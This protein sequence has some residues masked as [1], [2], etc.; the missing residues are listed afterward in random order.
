MPNPSIL[1]IDDDQDVRSVLRLGL[2]QEGWSIYEAADRE[3]MLSVVQSRNVD[4]VTLDLNLQNIDGLSLARELRAIQ[5]APILII[6]ARGQP[7]ERVKGLEQGADDYITKP[8]HIRE[9]VLRIKRLLS[10]YSQPLQDAQ[11]LRLDQSIF[12]PSRGVLQD[13]SGS[14]ISL[15]AQEKKLL[16]I[17]T[18]NP[19]RVL[20]RDQ[21]AQALTGRDWSPLD[22]TIDVHVAH[23]RRKL[24]QLLNT[25]IVIR[26]VRGV[27]YVFATPV[28]RITLEN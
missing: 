1:V 18:Q 2:A 12:D 14:V 17:L 8:F 26:S 9:V 20:S 6:S 28:S 4:A 25:E 24:G 21:I 19:N 5:N 11:F 27:G 15:T 7:F 22:R 10:I 16:Q 23:L 13:P 3:E